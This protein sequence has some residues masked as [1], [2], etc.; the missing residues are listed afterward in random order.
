MTVSSPVHVEQSVSAP[1][2][3]PD[4]KK[5]TLDGSALKTAQRIH[6]TL[7][8][9]GPL[10]GTVTAITLLPKTGFGLLELGLL[11]VMFLATM[12]GISVGFHRYLAHGAFQAPFPVQAA[13]IICGCMA[14]Q[15]GPIYWVSNH[16][17]HHQFSDLPGD[18]HSPHHDGDTPL[19]GLRGLW[20]AHVE[21]TLTHKLT[22]ALFY[23]KDL[24]RNPRLGRLNRMYFVWVLLGFLLPTALGGLYH[25]TW[26][27]ALSGFLWGGMVRLFLSYHATSSINSITHRFGSRPFQTREHSTNNAWLALLTVGESWHN[28]HHAFQTSAF[29]GLRWWQIDLG[30]WLIWALAK[31][32]LASNVHEPT[33]EMIHAK[34]ADP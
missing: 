2:S 31:S 27:G 30:A 4:M 29:F 5:I 34:L 1:A 11:A 33:P 7:L 17:R 32:G 21:W 23:C 19:G 12:L 16:R 3:T 24:I 14:A 10:V 26:M 28:N 25:G 18:P 8:F 6:A 15:G 20:H 22:N 9:I 13:L